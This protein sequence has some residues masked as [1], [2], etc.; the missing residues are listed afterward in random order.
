MCL[1]LL[2][3][4]S[5]YELEMLEAEAKDSEDEAEGTSVKQPSCENVNKSPQNLKAGTSKSCEMPKTGEVLKVSHNLS[6]P[7]GLSRVPGHLDVCGFKG[8][9]S[10]DPPDPK[11]RTPISTRTSND[12]EFISRIVERPSHSDAKYNATISYTRRT[13]RRSPSSISPGNSGNTRGSPKVILSESV[14]K[15][16]AKVLNPSVTNADQG[17]EPT[18]LVDGPS[19]INNHSPLGNTGRSVHDMSSMNAVLNSHANSSTAKSS[20]FSRNMFTED[21]AF[22]ANMVLETGENENANKKTPQPSSRDLRENNLVLRS[23]SGGFV[24]ERYEQMVAEAGEPQNQQQDGGGPFSLKKELEIDKSDMLSDLLVLRA[25]KDDF[26]TKPVRKKMIAKKTLGSRSKLKSNESQKGSI[27]LNATAVQNDPTV[28]MAEVKEREEDG[29]FSDATELETSLATINVAVTEKMETE[30][31]TKLGNNIE[32]KIGFMDDETEAP[33]EKNDSENFLEEEQAGMIDLPHKADN[34]IEMKLEAD[35]SA[36]YMRNG[37]VEGKNPVEIQKRDGSIL[38]EDFV[39]GKGRKQPSDKTNTTTATS[40]VRKEESKKV[41]N[42]EEN[43]NG[44][45]IEENAAEKESTEPHRAGQGK[46]RIISRKKSK[47]SVDAEKEN[48]PAVDGDQYASLDDK[49]V[50]ETAAKSNKAPVKFNQ[51]VSKS[52]LGSTT[53]REVTKQVKAEPLWFILSGHRLQRKEYQKVIKSLKGK[54]CRDSHQWSYQATHYIAPGP[55]RRTEKFFAAAASGRWILKTDYLTAC[56]QA[57]RFLA[58]ESYEWHKNGLSEDGTINLE[59]PRKWRLL[60]E[61]T[62]HGAFYGMRI[63]IYGECM[64]PPLDTLKRVVKAGDGTILATSPPYT[65]FLTSGVDFAIISPGIT[66]ADV[67]VQE[68]LK[69]KIPCIVADYLVEYVCKPGNSLE[70]HV[71]YN[72]NDL[73][74]KSFSNLLSKV[75]VIPEDLTMPKDCDS[76]NDIACEVCCSCDRGEDMLICGDE[77]GSVGC[78]AGIHIDCCD[79]PLESIPEEDWFCSKCSGSRSTSP[80]KKRIKKALH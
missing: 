51:K 50:G 17:S 48:K 69:H 56:S 44:K 7:E 54:L 39:K 53:G 73:A 32:D 66:R 25:G 79:P 60:R 72:T 41:L 77:C 20:K 5:G 34:K 57:G 35:N 22:L 42:M 78:G 23:D 28:T 61:R 24:V 49:R 80:K 8:A 45:N 14:N 36:A 76:G 31:A 38:T 3:L 27:N 75:N 63:I 29:N 67:W 10:N 21:N 13:P 58:E 59:A 74:E 9:S 68:F 70:R 16:S 6:E 4:N 64:T 26:I 12:L 40:I 52:N 15:S 43:L 1:T 18:H 71:L 33:E 46:S 2:Y 65:R 11:E 55:I 47:N 19:R 62:G 30:S 37:P